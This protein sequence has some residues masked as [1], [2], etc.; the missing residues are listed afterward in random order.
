MRFSL[1]VLYLMATAHGLTGGVTAEP[2][3]GQTDPRV[4][5]LLRGPSGDLFLTNAGA[6]MQ[7]GGSVFRW[8]YPGP[9]LRVSRPLASQWE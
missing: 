2:N 1:S 5:Y 4:L 6:V 9:R 8:S 7:S 3:L